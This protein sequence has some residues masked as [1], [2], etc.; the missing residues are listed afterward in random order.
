MNCKILDICIS[1]TVVCDIFGGNQSS[2]CVIN[3]VHTYQRHMLFKHPSYFYY[4]LIWL[5]SCSAAL[6]L[7][8][9]GLLF[10]ESPNVCKVAAK[11]A[12]DLTKDKAFSQQISTIFNITFLRY[13]IPKKLIFFRENRNSFRKSRSFG[14]SGDLAFCIGSAN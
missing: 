6:T 3:M 8:S 1:Y 4:E 11:T 9:G 10:F 7:D 2:L 5:P 14:R 12:A 13:C